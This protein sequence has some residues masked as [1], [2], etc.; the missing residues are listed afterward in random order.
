MNH[1]PYETFIWFYGV[2]EDVKDPLE[3]GRVRV[4]CLGFH[5]GDTNAIPKE[6]LPWAQTL[7]PTISPS[8]GGIGMSS[9][10]LKQGSWVFGFFQ[11]G[12]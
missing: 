12:K 6:T 3:L 8:I 9:T 2:V 7:S 11:D 4:R 1:T 10:G 5:N